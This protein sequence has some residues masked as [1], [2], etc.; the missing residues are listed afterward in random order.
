MKALASGEEEAQSARQ[1]LLRTWYA[2]QSKPCWE[3]IV[4]ALVL[5]GDLELAKKVAN[6]NDILWVET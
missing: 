1:A 6:E 4:D 5:S 2:S 3:N